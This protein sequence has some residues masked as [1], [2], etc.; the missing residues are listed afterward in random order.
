MDLTDFGARPTPEKTISA[1]G[2]PEAR[3]M[4]TTGLRLD[5]PQ[6]RGITPDVS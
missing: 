6:V 5:H 3:F 1:D 2:L 4:I